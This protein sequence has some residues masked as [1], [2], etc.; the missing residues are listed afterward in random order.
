MRSSQQYTLPFFPN[1]QVSLLWGKLHL[2]HYPSESFLKVLLS[3]NSIFSSLPCGA[4]FVL[5][6]VE[7]VLWHGEV[8]HRDHVCTPWSCVYTIYSAHCMLRSVS[9]FRT[10]CT[11]H[12]TGSAMSLLSLLLFST[13]GLSPWVHLWSDHLISLSGP[14]GPSVFWEPL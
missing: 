1:I 2:T 9:T 4:F 10:P 8:V 5:L 12:T 3:K 13:G 6:L 14:R 7:M 11:G